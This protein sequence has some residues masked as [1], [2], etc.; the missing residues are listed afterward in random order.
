M[1]KRNKPVLSQYHFLYS[2][3]FYPN[4]TSPSPLRF[5]TISHPN[6]LECP[7]HFRVSVLPSVLLAPSPP[8]SLPHL[9]PSP[10]QSHFHP[11]P[12][13]FAPRTHKSS[14]YQR[15]LF[16][17]VLYNYF[18]GSITF[19]LAAIYKIR[20]YSGDVLSKYEF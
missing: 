6:L 19:Y 11:C 17:S 5:S 10:S 4:P 7:P 12:P 8:H 15:Y 2:K 16:I 9:I 3:I 18:C 13:P 20:F 1:K 14:L